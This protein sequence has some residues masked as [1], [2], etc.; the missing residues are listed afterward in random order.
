MAHP[1]VYMPARQ[2]PG[3]LVN[4]K[5]LINTF[6]PKGIE[7][8]EF[9]FLEPGDEYTIVAVHAEANNKTM[10][11]LLDPETNEE[12]CVDSRALLIDVSSPA[13]EA[14]A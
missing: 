13:P 6:N 14:V 7:V 3:D 2:V 11:D 12:F 1:S 5:A 9:Y 10:I 4:K 8:L